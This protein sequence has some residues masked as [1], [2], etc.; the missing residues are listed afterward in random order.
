M[1]KPT[2]I[3][4]MTIISSLKCFT[5]FYFFSMTF[6]NVVHQIIFYCENF[7]TITTFKGIPSRK[8]VFTY[9]LE[10][11]S[12]TN[13]MWFIYFSPSNI[14]EKRVKNWNFLEIVVTQK[15]GVA[16]FL[17]TQKSRVAPFLVIQKAE[18]L[19][20]FDTQKSGVAP[21]LIS[22]YRSRFVSCK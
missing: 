21:F 18:S 2:I 6:L 8:T 1:C 13:N 17:D 5:R 20:F 3:F 12:V 19:L 16:P 11:H 9:V 4:I 22:K 14:G 7:T 10:G 15:S